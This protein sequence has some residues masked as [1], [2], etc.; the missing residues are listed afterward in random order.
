MA[1]GTTKVDKEDYWSKATQPYQLA[2]ETVG[3]RGN[4]LSRLG[5][6]CQLE[7]DKEKRLI[8]S[9]NNRCEFFAIASIGRY[10]EGDKW[11]ES[12]DYKDDKFSEVVSIPEEALTRNPLNISGGYD[13]SSTCI[14]SPSSTILLSLYRRISPI[15]GQIQ[16]R[17]QPKALLLQ[18]M[19][20]QTTIEV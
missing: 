5:N 14:C 3:G 13:P 4:F 18:Q 2:V 11:K 17:Q 20:A 19:Q 7:K 16:K 12:V 10:L 1:F 9:S 6:Y 15:P 8:P